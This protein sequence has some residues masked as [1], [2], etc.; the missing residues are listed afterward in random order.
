MPIHRI[1]EHGDWI[2]TCK[3][4]PQQFDKWLSGVYNPEDDFVTIGGSQ[5][6]K[7][8]CSLTPIS[9]AYAEFFNKHKLWELYD[10]HYQNFELYEEAV[11]KVCEVYKIQFEGI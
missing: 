4:E 2:F 8:H 1:V 5:H 6:S 9:D 10:I 3:M 11:K 7:T